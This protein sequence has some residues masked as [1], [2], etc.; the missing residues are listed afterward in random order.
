MA[1]P[2]AGPGRRRMAP[3]LLGIVAVLA[4]AA[5]AVTAAKPENRE[6]PR[7]GTEGGGGPVALAATLSP[8]GTR[9][10]IAADTG[11]D[12]ADELYLVSADGSGLR[13]VATGMTFYPTA[14][15]AFSADGGQI[16]FVGYAPGNESPAVFRV[17]V[18]G[19]GQTRLSEFSGSLPAFSPDGTRIAFS[20]SPADGDGS[21]DSD[22]DADSGSDSDADAEDLYVAN[23]DGTGRTALT[24]MK[25]E[26]YAPAFSPDGGLV[27]FE[28]R[29]SPG[30]PSVWVVRADGSRARRVT[31]AD[32]PATS[33]RFTADGKRLVFTSGIDDSAAEY[34]AYSVAVTSPGTPEPYGQGRSASHERAGKRVYVEDGDVYVENIDG[35]DRRRLTDWA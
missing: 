20:V 22:S 10:A 8:D 35:S 27:A 18:D 19:A 31:P 24:S 3:A 13:G 4:A 9:V 32:T 6:G 12:A 33:P 5:V 1:D 23:V 14:P 21:S 16:L 26:E 28:R 11:D 2:A 30:L 7:S 17:R 25:G 34:G 15:L 29:V